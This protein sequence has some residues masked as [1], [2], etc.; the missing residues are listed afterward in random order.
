VTNLFDRIG[1]IMVNML[2]TSMADR[3][4][5]PNRVIGKTSKLVSAASPLSM[6]C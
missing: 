1:D 6:Q 5:E 2:A 3:G 4:F